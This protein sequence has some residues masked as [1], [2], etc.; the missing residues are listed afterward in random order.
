MSVANKLLATCLTAG[1]IGLGVVGL[2]NAGQKEFSSDGAV[3]KTPGPLTPRTA[4]IRGIGVNGWNRVYGD[5]AATLRLVGQMN[6]AVGGAYNPNGP[7]PLPIDNNTPPTTL[8]GTYADP[9]VYLA[10]FGVPDAQN[11]PNQNIP[12]ADYPQFIHHDG[13]AMPME[14]LL[15]NQEW[16]EYSNGAMVKDYTVGDWLSG[17]GS[18]QFVC[19]ETNGHYFE[20]TMKNMVPGGLYTIWGFYFDTQIGMLQQDFPFGGTSANVYV[21]DRHGDIHGSRW[22][23]FCPMDVDPSERMQLVNLFVVYHADGNVYAAIGH[24][25][26]TPPF[27]G[28]G[29]TATPQVMFPVPESF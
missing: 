16:W 1:I 4:S 13:Q 5:P 18:I 19:D 11:S 26:A 22:L 15:D 25:V 20:L 2:S 8:M 21:A 6:M 28:P 9:E 7:D 24:E 10:L 14:Q 3:T 12:Y 27:I 29:V 23:N 17:E